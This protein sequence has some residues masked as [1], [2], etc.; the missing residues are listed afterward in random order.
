VS[1]RLATERLYYALDRARRERHIKW[2]DIAEGAGVSP[3]TLTRIGQGH[4][5]DA[6]GVI[7]LMIWLG[8]H[9]IRDF[10]EAASPTNPGQETP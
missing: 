8:R 4:N 10:V 5:P 2:R 3:S 1:A 6:N 7:R 9:D